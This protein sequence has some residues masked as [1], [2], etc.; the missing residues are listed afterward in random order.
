[1]QKIRKTK[2]KSIMAMFLAMALML[3]ILPGTSVKAA[4]YSGSGTLADPYLVQTAEQLQGMRDNLSAH[5]KLANTIDLS[6]M[7]FKPIGRLDAPFT[8]SFICELN[9]DNTPK[10]A[11]KNLSVAVAETP[12]VSGGASKWEA[13]LFGAVSGTTISGIYVLDAKI[14]N[15]NFGDN[16]GAIAYGDYKPGMNEMPTAILIGDA[17]NSNIANCATT[18]VVDARS[19]TCAGFVGQTSNCTIENCYTTATVKSEGRWDTAGFVGKCYEASTFNK[20]FATGNVTAN[21]ESAGYGEKGAF[22]G[23]DL[24]GDDVFTECYATGTVTPNDNLF[25]Q[26][27]VKWTPGGSMPSISGI[28]VVTDASKY[29]PGAVEQAPATQTG[30]TQ[31]GTTT[32]SDTT[33]GTTIQSGTTAGATTTTSPDEV[34]TLIEALPDPAAENSI[35]VEHKDAIKE[36]WKAYESMTM[37]DKD[38]FDATLAAKLAGCR[39]Q[40]SMLIAADW[41]TDVEALPKAEELT[42]DDI[43]QINALWDDY[44]F[45]DDTLVAEVDEALIAKLEEAHEFAEKNANVIPGTLVEVDNGLTKMETIVVIFCLS[46]FVLVMA[47]NVFACITIM[48]RM[49]EVGKGKNNTKE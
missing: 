44:L 29:V 15:D 18:G 3:S 9:A 40:V 41:V 11:I 37:G 33:A 22:F 10:Y 13:A 14:S 47:F 45:L 28:G 49:R 17:E 26:S 34:K 31:S 4:T 12:Y 32:Q 16:T 36:A 5:Y 19:N 8:G 46:V 2:T 25:D 35:T 7:D 24:E 48:K 23:A 20:C 27:T 38:D 39:L 42:I 1:M 30:T 6:G 21:S 43:E